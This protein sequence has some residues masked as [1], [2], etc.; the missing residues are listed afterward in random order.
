MGGIDNP[1]QQEVLEQAEISIKYESYIEKEF[2]YVEKV[3]RL[4]DVQLYED[5]DYSRIT[6]L[7]LE[8]K[9]KLSKLKPRTLGQASRISGIS[10][11]DISVLMVYIGR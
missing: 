5:F 2:E 9:Q 8:A 1:I 3:N 10:P 4:E 7:S 6:S 11:A